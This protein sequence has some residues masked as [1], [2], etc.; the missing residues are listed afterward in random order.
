MPVDTNICLSLIDVK[1]PSDKPTK[2]KELN[3]YSNMVS[4]AMLYGGTKEKRELSSFLKETMPQFLSAYKLGKTSQEALYIQALQLLLEEGVAVAA[5]A[6]SSLAPLT[7]LPTT[8][9]GSPGASDLSGSIADLSLNPVPSLRL[10]DTYL[11]AFQRVLEVILFFIFLR[12]F[13]FLCPCFD[14]GL[15]P[16][17]I[18]Y[19]T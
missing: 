17:L 6:V 13:S 11:N 16:Y 2:T 4:R 19:C 18:C 15:I 1:F 8:E 14:N 3:A 9:S 5:S 7:V 10:Y 12:P